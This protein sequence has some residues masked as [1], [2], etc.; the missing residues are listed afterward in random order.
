MSTLEKQNITHELEIKLQVSQRR[1]CSVLGF[2]R[3]SI[4][5]EKKINYEEDGLTE[6]VLELAGQYGRYGYRR[7]TA[8]LNHEG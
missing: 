5:R 2:N 8:L 1:I 6:R 7:I 3:T 4:R